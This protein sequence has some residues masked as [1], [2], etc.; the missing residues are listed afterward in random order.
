MLNWKKFEVFLTKSEIR[1][2]YLLSPLLFT[3]VLKDLARE[4][5]QMRKVKRV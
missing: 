2:G 3:I 5:K 1:Q 4:I